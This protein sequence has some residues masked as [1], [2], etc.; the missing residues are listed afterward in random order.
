MKLE[1]YLTT[2]FESSCY[3]T[4]QFNSFA[5]TYKNSVKKQIS[6]KFEIVS[7]TNG[8]FFISYFVKNTENNNIAYISISDVRYFPNGWYNN[9]LVRTAKDLKDFSG[10]CNTYC[11]FDNL[12]SQ[13]DNLTKGT[14]KVTYNTTELQEEFKVISF[15]APYVFVV[16]ISD[17]KKGTLQFN[18]SPRIYY[19]FMETE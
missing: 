2:E 19:N 4:K 5:R 1:Q 18:H 16:R 9:I 11:N 6:P 17:G 10:G 15:L 7:T 12:L 3:K 13:L 14:K 8:H